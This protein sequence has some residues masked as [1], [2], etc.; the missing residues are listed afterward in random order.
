MIAN[1]PGQVPTGHLRDEQL[2]PPK[3]E[4]GADTKPR[5]PFKTSLILTREQEDALVKHAIDRVKQLE[6]QLGR[7]FKGKAAAGKSMGCTRRS[8]TRIRSWGNGSATPCAITITWRTGR[9][10]R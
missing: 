1:A 10:N 2:P 8:R 9:G 3:H 4:P 6:D 7:K 5:M